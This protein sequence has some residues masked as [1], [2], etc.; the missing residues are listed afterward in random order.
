MEEFDAFWG[1]EREQ[2]KKIRT[3]IRKRYNLD[4]G[5]PLRR[6][7]QELEVM[8]GGKLRPE[9]YDACPSGCVAF[10][11]PYTTET[12][13]PICSAPRFHENTAK[14]LKRWQYIPL[15]PRLL[16]QYADKDRARQ[17]RV[18]REEFTLA[19]EPANIKD[20]FDG[21]W[22]RECHSNGYFQDTRDLALR[23]SLD[24][25]GLTENAP[26]QLKVTPVVLFNLNLHP[27]IRDKAANSLTSF[28]IPGSFS[29]ERIDTWL[30]PL[31]EELKF[32]QQ[33]I[34]NIWD[35]YLEQR[36]TLRAHIILVTGT[37]HNILYS[38]RLTCV[39]ATAGRLLILW[40]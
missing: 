6:A 23:L 26:P 20:V 13:C 39:Q 8:L 38:I 5:N 30:Q 35:A 12:C 18:Y 32:L 15:I 27:S 1:I 31:M 29:A 2:M 28:I 36:F 7:T 24:S 9:Y 10:T 21:A 22:F 25:I 33:G 34:P 17:L 16:I 40:V 4:I 14:P 11:G 37:D 19:T 3:V